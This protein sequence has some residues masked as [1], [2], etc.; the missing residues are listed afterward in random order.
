LARQSWDVARCIVSAA[1]ALALT[2]LAP[3][4]LAHDSGFG[5][6]RY[7][8]DGQLDT[9]FGQG[10]IVVTRSQ[11]SSF[12]ANALALQT[13]G[14]IVLGGMLSDVSSGRLDLAVAR[15]NSDGT[16]DPSFGNLGLV[17][18][19]VGSA[20]GEANAISIER[21]AAILVA[22]TAF[23]QGSAGDA[24][25]V[26]RYTRNG[27]LDATFG[28][29][30]ITTTQLGSGASTAAA[31]TVL[32]DDRVIIVGTAYSNG[33][34]DDD[35][36]TARYTSAG[37][38]DQSFGNA[39]IVTTDFG[40]S[41]V[42]TSVDRA[43]CLVVQPDGKLVVAGFTRGA[44]QSFAVARYTPEGSLDSG[45]GTSGKFQIDAVEPQV[46][47]VIL[48][49]SGD[50]V[51]AGSTSTQSGT[52]PFALVRLLSDGTPDA[53]FGEGGLVSTAFEGSRSG[54]RA[55]IAQ[56]DGKLVTGGARFGAPSAQG[57]ALAQSGFA[58]AR[59]KAD[60]SIDA[61]FGAG[62]R[63]LT[64]L[65]DAGAT[66]LSLAVQSDGKIL[67]AGLVFFQVQSTPLSNPDVSS[68]ALVG[69]AIAAFIALG[70][71]SLLRRRK[72]RETLAST[73]PVP[74]SSRTK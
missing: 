1:L 11:Q 49:S 62:G 52:A 67:A 66:P 68:V 35:F 18:T 28:T 45:F 19:P 40:S 44:R 20:G 25:L 41:G 50:I 32:P 30:G 65:G 12:V 73:T 17:S 16:P 51:L 70:L 42:R 7:T 34:T 38:L 43:T 15:Y 46:F 37:R 5:L 74:R 47:A 57:D 2:L 3:S 60:G 8:P 13:D 10:G 24:A 9:S 71:M 55:V 69:L 58:L 64:D 72:R 48:Q 27:V 23:S 54:A 39:G 29:A 59:Y 56:P 21:D 53:L 14:K 63:E 33:P 22:G 31:L 61:T 6:A 36:A 4:V 26:A